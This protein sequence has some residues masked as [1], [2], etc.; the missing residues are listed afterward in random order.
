MRARPALTCPPHN[1][2]CKMATWV[3]VCSVRIAGSLYVPPLR[4][5]VGER[6]AFDAITASRTDSGSAHSRGA[7][8]PFDT[9]EELARD[10]PG[11]LWRA[12]VIALHFSA[13]LG[14]NPFHLLF[15]FD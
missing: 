8:S 10:L 7:C 9:R 13:T 11:G 2:V 1:T 5:C 14:A 4:I 15:R 6:T 12:E 3:F